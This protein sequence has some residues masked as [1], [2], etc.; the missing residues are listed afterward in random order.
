MRASR[1]LPHASQD[2]NGSIEAY[3]GFLKIRFL[4]AY[5]RLVGRRIDWLIY[6]LTSSVVSHYWYAQMM[7]N[8]GFIRNTNIKGLVENSFEKALSI[9]NDHVIYD[10]NHMECVQVQS[11]SKPGVIYKVYGASTDWACCTCRNAE[12]GNICKH[13]IK[14]MLLNNN[15]TRV[16]KEQCIDLY[17]S[18]LPR[19]CNNVRLISQ[20]I[21][22]D[23]LND[24]KVNEINEKHESSATEIGKIRS[25]ISE[26]FDRILL[27]IG[28]NEMLGLE[29]LNRFKKCEAFIKQ[30]KEESNHAQL[31]FTVVPDG[32]SNSLMR[33]KPFFEK[34]RSHRQIGSNL[35]PFQAPQGMK[36]KSMQE[37]LDDNAI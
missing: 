22:S 8:I 36:R 15:S 14:V 35:E 2:T 34:H 7:K 5:K 27:E 4:G 29:V 33:S 31:G 18:S 10:N 23:S 17:N 28:D 12:L 9:P 3:H 24:A 11:I 37:K 13:Q 1:S 20:D 16:V 21:G 26:S 32:F 19:V 25:K 6:T 30:T